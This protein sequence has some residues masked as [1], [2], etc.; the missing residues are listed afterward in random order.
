MQSDYLTGLQLF[1]PVLCTLGKN[2]LWK[3]IREPGDSKASYTEY[4]RLFCSH[5][6]NIS[7]RILDLWNNIILFNSLQLELFFSHFFSSSLVI[8]ALRKQLEGWAT[9]CQVH[10]LHWVIVYS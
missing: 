7:V 10:E 6:D 3:I 5:F 8:C 1:A 4:C 9:Y 2:N